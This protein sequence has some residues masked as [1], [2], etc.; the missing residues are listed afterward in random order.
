MPPRTGEA[1][2]PGKDPAAP[3]KPYRDGAAARP[4]CAMI[5]GTKRAV[6]TPATAMQHEKIHEKG[7]GWVSV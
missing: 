2:E 5:A 7:T 3:R 1:A 4:A 6:V